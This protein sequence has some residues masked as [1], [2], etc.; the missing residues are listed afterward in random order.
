M[1]VFYIYGPSLDKRLQKV[2]YR[3]F[4][5]VYCLHDL[6]LR[7]KDYNIPGGNFQKGKVID[8]YWLN[9]GDPVA[10]ELLGANDFTNATM[11]HLESLT[12]NYKN[13]NRMMGYY[14]IE[15]YPNKLLLSC[16]GREYKALI[17][18]IKVHHHRLIQLDSIVDDKTVEYLHKAHNYGGM[19]VATMTKEARHIIDES[20][21]GYRFVSVAQ[22]MAYIK[23]F[24]KAFPHI[25]IEEKLQRGI[26]E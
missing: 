19:I 6:H 4:A 7:L 10:M 17:R 8:Y 16:S 22:F 25:K 26:S 9:E 24:K 1:N 14:G 2:V 12:N 18:Q 21:G 5:D 13:H 11:H 3:L 15:L 23:E 20:L